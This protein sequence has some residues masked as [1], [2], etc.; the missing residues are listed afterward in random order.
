MKLLNN[1]MRQT[2]KDEELNFGEWLGLL[3]MGLIFLI[4]PF[5]VGRYLYPSPKII[6]KEVI[7]QVPM[8]T[9][10]PKIP[11]FKESRVQQAKR[12]G[13]VKNWMAGY[14][15]CETADNRQFEWDDEKWTET[16]ESQRCSKYGD[17]KKSDVPV[18]CLDYWN[19]K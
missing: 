5:A 6:E 4:I 7:K 10:V 3:L 19:L 12:V 11:I 16:L 13:C 9:P 15:P 1:Y 8:P 17:Y 14:L 18:A 2:K